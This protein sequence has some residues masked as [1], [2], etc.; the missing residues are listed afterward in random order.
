MQHSVIDEAN[1][2]AFYR[3]VVRPLTWLGGAV[4]TAMIIFLF[5][6][7]VYAIFMRYV[8]DSPSLWVDE[9]TG[10]LLVAIVMLGSAEAYRR[11][12]HI[13]V[14]LISSRATGIWRKLIEFIADLAVLFFGIVLGISTW[15]AISFAKSF[16][17][18]TTGHIEMATWVLQVPMLVGSVL[19]ALTAVT[20]IV[21]RI[22]KI[23]KRA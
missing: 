15:E 13:A 3:Y 5:F 10:W 16:G 14:D 8:L 6:A 11:G 17:S 12:D 23:I 18:Y 19:F 22:I 21:E 7:T 9:V 4:S 20:R 1:A 2:S